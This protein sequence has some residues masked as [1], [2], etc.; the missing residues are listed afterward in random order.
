MSATHFSGPVVSSNGFTGALTGD[1]VATTVTAS[2][3]VAIGSGTAITKVVKGTI[4]V[5]PSS[6][7]TLTG[8]VLTLTITGAAV[9]DAVILHPPAAGLTA[10][11][12]VGQAYVSATDTVKVAV[13][14]GSAGTIDEASAT[15]IYTLIRS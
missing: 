7:L 2:T 6:L 14:N 5:N 1:V 11:M 13:F 10:G 3:S 4:A 15:W 8:E 9:G 12:L